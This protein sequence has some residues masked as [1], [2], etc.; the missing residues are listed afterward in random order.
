MSVTGTSALL[1]AL[2]GRPGAPETLERSAVAQEEAARR[3]W[4]QAC[5][6]HFL[7]SGPSEAVLTA[8]AAMEEARRVVARVEAAAAAARERARIARSARR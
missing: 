3:R 2:G 8:E 1:E 7:D 4:E 6:A 5:A